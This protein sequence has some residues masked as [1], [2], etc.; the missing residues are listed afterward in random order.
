MTNGERKKKIERRERAEANRKSN[1]S[2]GH[3]AHERFCRTIAVERAC[4]V[5]PIFLNS[6]RRARSPSAGARSL[7]REKWLGLNPL[8]IEAV[9][10]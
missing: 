8:V 2:I 6:Y 3:A 7:A 9:A 10:S 1:L 4:G 5:H